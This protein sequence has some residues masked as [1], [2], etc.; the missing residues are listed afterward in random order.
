MTCR[1]GAPG[2]GPPSTVVLGPPALVHRLI[3]T[4]TYFEFPLTLTLSRIGGEG[5]N[6]VTTVFLPLPPPGGEGRG[7][8]G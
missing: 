3:N 4:L 2:A 8:G 7:E 5:I 1:V 6:D